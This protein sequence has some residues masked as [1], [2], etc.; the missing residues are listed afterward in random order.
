MAWRGNRLPNLGNRFE[1]YQPGNN[2][3]E[4]E[5]VLIIS[6]FQKGKL[7]ANRKRKLHKI[8]T[9]RNSNDFILAFGT[10]FDFDFP[11]LHLRD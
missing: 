6:L 5:R 8:W 1:P 7:N 9:V 10:G 4:N 11:D 3:R 2:L